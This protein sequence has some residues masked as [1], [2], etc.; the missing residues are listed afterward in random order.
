MKRS[1][2][3]RYRYKALKGDR[4]LTPIQEALLRT[5]ARVYVHLERTSEL[6][7]KEPADEK[8]HARVLELTKTLSNLLAKVG[9]KPVNLSTLLSDE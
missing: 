6:L 1:T 7:L 8:L 9:E 2:A 3:V 5:A 4:K